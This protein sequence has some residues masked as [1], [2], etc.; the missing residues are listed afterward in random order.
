MLANSARLGTVWP[1]VDEVRPGLPNTWPTSARRC[2]IWAHSGHGCSK[3]G[4][5]TCVGGNR[6]MFLRWCPRRP[7][8]HPN[9]CLALLAAIS[10]VG[11]GR[12]SSERR[13][14]STRCGSRA[15]AGRH[16]QGHG[17]RD[18]GREEEAVREG[19]ER[20]A[21]PAGHHHLRRGCEPPPRVGERTWR[22]VG[23]RVSV[24]PEEV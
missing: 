23:I 4:R 14:V 11:Q 20:R 17:R 6:G 3:H 16:R 7:G 13:S 8:H 15:R 2:R 19:E 22:V 9:T 12:S 5:E 24:R 21:R 1:E 10:Q 18:G